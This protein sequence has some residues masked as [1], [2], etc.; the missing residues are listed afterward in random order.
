VRSVTT[1][2]LGSNRFVDCGALVAFRN[3]GSGLRVETA[4]LRVTLATPTDLP[5]GRA[6]NV[7]RNEQSPE[8]P[9][10]KI[11]KS[12][13]SVAIFWDD[14][15]LVIATQLDAETV[16]LRAD[17]RPIGI[18]IYDDATGL[19]IGGMHLSQNAFRGASVA[20]QLG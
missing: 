10:V 17:L 14:A 1:V 15:P 18:N 9:H 16:N 8:S 12:E 7:V 2:V 11:V 6:I 20:F 19:H 13:T 3:Q 5:S 4:P